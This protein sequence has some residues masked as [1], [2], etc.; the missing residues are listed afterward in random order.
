MCIYRYMM[1]EAIRAKG[2]RA[3][4]Q[5]LC[6]SEDEVRSFILSLP[7]PLCVVK[8]NE[9]AGSDHVYLCRGSGSA[10]SVILEAMTAFK[11]IHGQ[12]NGL[13]QVNDGALVQEFLSGKEYVLDGVSRDGVYKVAAIWEYDKRSVNGANFV[14]FGMKLL[15]GDDPVAKKLVEY[16]RQVVAALEISHGPSHMEV[17]YV[18]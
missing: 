8:P 12:L 5:K 10:E 4:G 9:S 7:T 3:V 15:S 1:Q 2:V 14:Y 16:G 13:G 11:Q 6:R 18:I 17:C